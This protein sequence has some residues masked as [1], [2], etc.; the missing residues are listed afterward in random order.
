MWSLVHKEPYRMALY[1]DLEKRRVL[2]LRGKGVYVPKE[3]KREV[4]HLL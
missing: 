3:G 2:Q 4:S 1:S